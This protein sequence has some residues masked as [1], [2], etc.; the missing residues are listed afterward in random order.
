METN[1]M[2]Y[3]IYKIK[4]IQDEKEQNTSGAVKTDK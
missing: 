2:K 3:M 1:E 4:D